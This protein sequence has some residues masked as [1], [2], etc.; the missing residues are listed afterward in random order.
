MPEKRFYLTLKEFFEDSKLTIDTHCQAGLINEPTQFPLRGIE[1]EGAVLF[2]DLPGFSAYASKVSLAECAYVV[3]HFFSWMSNVGVIGT[4]GILDNF[5]GD[6][7]LVVYIDSVTDGFSK[8]LALFSAFQMLEMDSFAFE[9]R[10]GI[11]YGKFMVSET[12]TE[13]FTTF[14]SIG[15][16]VNLAAR[17]V[18]TAPSKSCIRIADPDMALIEQLFYSDSWKVDGPKVVKLKNLPDVTVADVSFTKSGSLSFD[19]FK[20]VRKI[21]ELA[22]KGG[23]A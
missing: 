8:Q 16:P 19:Y 1:V 20:K 3:N 11:A 12:G 5:I 15:H 10:I 4:G 18:S 21:V 17:C 14:S 2:A 13:H 22:K 23:P 7:F 6:E 9:P